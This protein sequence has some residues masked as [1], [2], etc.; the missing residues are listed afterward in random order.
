M[1]QVQTPFPSK[2]PWRLGVFSVASTRAWAAYVGT[3]VIGLALPLFDAVYNDS[4]D[5]HPLQPDRLVLRLVGMSF[6]AANFAIVGTVAFRLGRAAAR[7]RKGLCPIC[8]YDV[9]A[10]TDRCP[11]CGSPLAARA[12]A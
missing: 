4:P 1:Q 9:R 6:I 5:S 8:G 7:L 3:L 10:S 12:A 11:E 2:R